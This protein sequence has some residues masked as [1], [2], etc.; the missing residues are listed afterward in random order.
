MYLSDGCHL[1]SHDE[2]TKNVEGNSIWQNY[3]DQIIDISLQHPDHFFP[4]TSRKIIPRDA[5]NHRLYIYYK[6]GKIDAFCIIAVFCDEAEYLWAATRR[7]VVRK[8]IMRQLYW[9]IE[10]EIKSK[11]PEVERINAMCASLDSNFINDSSLTQQEVAKRKDFWRGTHIFHHKMNFDFTYKLKHRWGI[12]Y[13]ALVCMKVRANFGIRDRRHCSLYG[14][15]FNQLQ[16]IQNQLRE[17]ILKT[18]K[19]NKVDGK[20]LEI[21]KKIQE[22]VRACLDAFDESFVRNIQPGISGTEEYIFNDITDGNPDHLTPKLKGFTGLA[23]VNPYTGTATAFAHTSKDSNWSSHELY[24]EF[25]YSIHSPGLLQ[26]IISESSRSGFLIHP[27]KLA[28]ISE[29]NLK[30][31]FETFY[32]NDKGKIYRG[33]YTIFYRKRTGKNGFYSILYF[34]CPLIPNILWYEDLWDSFSNYSFS[35]LLIIL[36]YFSSL[37]DLDSSLRKSDYFNWLIQAVSPSGSD[38]EW[39]T[40]DEEWITKI[41]R[42]GEDMIQQDENQY[43]ARISQKNQAFKNSGHLMRNRCDNILRWLRFD[44]Q[45]QLSEE[46]LL[47]KAMNSLSDAYQAQQLWG[48]DSLDEIFEEYAEQHPNKDNRYKISRFLEKDDKLFD[49]SDFLQSKFLCREAYLITE[50]KESFNGHSS[51]LVSL[52]PKPFKHSYHLRSIIKNAEYSQEEFRLSKPVL[53]NIFFE[54]FL[55]IVRHGMVNLSE[56]KNRQGRGTVSVFFNCD[57]LDGSPAITIANPVFI[58]QSQ[59]VAKNRFEKLPTNYFRKVAG[60]LG[61]GLGGIAEYLSRLNL[62]KIGERRF[63]DHDLGL[64]FYEVAIH[65]RGLEVS[66]INQE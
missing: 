53:S 19:I 27:A 42:L 2:L 7:E 11:E 38:E 18:D 54:I 14:Y 22:H 39:T 49:L 46:S 26:Q 65:L 40:K 8:G 36:G 45:V 21:N 51:F 43:T 63:Y 29:I 3:I 50:I 33:D 57:R 35:L 48:F 9:F 61:S 10:D 28:E 56:H 66:E 23:L 24:D 41:S 16:E 13:H 34:A 12:G 4:K 25:E 20:N 5:K 52:D 55:N 1:V 44:P 15:S 64:D 17:S 58:T 6:D 59:Q 32:P 30:L 47:Y 37:R 62:G 31:Y 60:D